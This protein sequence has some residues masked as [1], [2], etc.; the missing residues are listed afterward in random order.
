L[1]A[2]VYRTV[3]DA[4]DAFGKEVSAGVYYYTIQSGTF[5]A[6]KSVVFLK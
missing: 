2:G 1:N 4:R 5:S 6:T 3:W